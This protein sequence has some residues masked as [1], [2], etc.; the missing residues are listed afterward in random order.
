MS[1][2]SGLVPNFNFFRENWQTLEH[3]VISRSVVAGI[4]KTG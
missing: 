3:H 4:R 2:V 1:Q